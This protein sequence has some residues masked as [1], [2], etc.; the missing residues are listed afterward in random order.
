MSRDRIIQFIALLVMIASA[1]VG[2]MLLPVM[3]DRS[4]NEYLR[5]T[6]DPVQ[7]TSP[8]I[9]LGTAIGALRGVLVDY[10]WIKTAIMKERGQF[11]EAM[12]DANMIARLQPRFAQVWAFLGHNLAYNISVSLNTPQERW[13][14]VK[15]GIDLV[16]NKGIRYNPNDLNLHRELAFWFKHK[17]EGVSDDA[18]LHY[19][20][21]FRHEWHYLLGEPPQDYQ[22]R[23]AWIKKIA[24]APETLEEAER[25]TPGVKALV[26]QLRNA[27]SPY[28]QR[29][30]FGLDKEFLRVVAL[31]DALKQDSA[32]ARALGLEA[33][34]RSDPEEG[35]L[36][37]AMDSIASNPA[38]ADAWNTLVLHVRKRVL[39]DE[40]NMDPQVMYEFTRDLGP[41]DWRHGEAHA[42]YW[43][44]LGSIRGERRII[45]PDEIYRRANNDRIQVQAMQS[46]A[47][48]GRI[49]LDPFD[50]LS[51]QIPSQFP[52]PLWIDAIE[53]EFNRLYVKYSDDKIR[54]MGGDL[55]IDFYQN[56][57]VAAVREYFRS[58]DVAR[59]EM[60]LKHLDNRF[61]TGGSPPDLRYIKP[62]EVFIRDETRGEYEYQP[63]LARQEVG[64]G[65]KQGLLALCVD[66]E[67][68]FQAA[69]RFAQ[70]ITAYFKGNDYNNYVNRFG[71]G[72]MSA[73]I[74]SLDM[75]LAAA[76]NQLMRDT[77]VDL[78]CRMTIWSK[79][80]QYALRDKVMA[81]DE[82]LRREVARHLQASYLGRNLT[83]DQVLPKPEGWDEYQQQMRI[84]QERLRQQQEQQRPVAPTPITPK[85]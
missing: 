85:S 47:K 59:A 19:K 23:I 16:R 31:R 75:S 55:F 26:E 21:Q 14:M 52:E 84:R 73:L 32:A 39:K 3:L 70:E 82:S 56:F 17:I 58:G 74:G 49:T 68:E 42:L 35:P 83:I 78:G 9:M 11:H 69:L 77:T 30:R 54:G 63:D 64:A 5:Y 80:D 44:R 67:D 57:M 48:G 62:I 10:L 34:F 4:R 79:L 41:I 15:A 25:I 24:D 36:Y 61:G 60:L 43:S 72:R 12:Q 18:H 53:R 20:R 46:L 71:E 22:A 37:D 29:F 27:L 45:D 40:Y 81:Y 8:I 38:N 6:D 28:E 1:A 33:K 50:N 13:E 7:S 76:I 65:L 2:G 66:R 51:D